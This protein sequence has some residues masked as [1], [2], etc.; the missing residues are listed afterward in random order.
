MR[1]ID[2]KAPEGNSFSLIGVAKRWGKQLELDVEEIQEDMMSG[3]YDH[4]IEVFEKHFSG[5]CE[6]VNK[7]CDEDD[8]DW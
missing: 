4:L 3:D 1:T 7:P 2:L 5:V 6:L 8:D